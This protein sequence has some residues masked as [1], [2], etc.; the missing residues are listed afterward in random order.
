MDTPDFPNV[1]FF[2]SGGEPPEEIKDMMRNTAASVTAHAMAVGAEREKA[3]DEFNQLIEAYEE[4]TRPIDDRGP[5]PVI[6]MLRKA[7]GYLNA[8]EEYQYLMVKEAIK[9]NELNREVVAITSKKHQATCAA[10]RLLNGA[11]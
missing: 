11:F 10:M 4:D 7:L 5:M 1:H 6:Q 9:D 3:V 2:S 8:V